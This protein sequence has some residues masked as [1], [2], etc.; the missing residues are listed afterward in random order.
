[1]MNARL[2]LSARRYKKR[3]VCH[4]LIGSLAGER[5]PLARDGDWCKSGR[6]M[7]G[8]T[9]TG[10]QAS[11]GAQQGWQGQRLNSGNGLSDLRIRAWLGR[12]LAESRE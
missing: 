2:A 10:G 6:Q 1:M 3:P 5:K 11:T 9:P 7:R 4:D 8:S 12:G